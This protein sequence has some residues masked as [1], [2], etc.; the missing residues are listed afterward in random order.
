MKNICARALHTLISWI[1]IS[2]FLRK[3]ALSSNENENKCINNCEKE[4]NR[5]ILLNEVT[6]SNIHNFEKLIPLNY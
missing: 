4:I 6:I 5:L 1:Q 3:S 2:I